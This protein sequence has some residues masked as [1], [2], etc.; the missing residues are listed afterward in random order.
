MDIWSE[1]NWFAVQTKP[2]RE[3]LAV[4]SVRRERVEVFFPQI[5]VNA[6][7]GD[8]TQK[9]SKPLFPGYLFA[10][11]CPS[12]ALDRVRYARGALRV[13]SA[14][15]IPLPVEEAI[16]REIRDRIE[17]DGLIRLKPPA[18][19]SGDPVLIHD[20]PLEGLMGRVEREWDDGRRVL[21]LIECLHQARVSVEKRSLLA[22][23][24]AA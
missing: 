14:S 16:I 11:F 7:D 9:V 23:C 12:A 24:E 4:A 8:A 20:G 21:I 22:G 5:V 17:P 2:Q 13:V 3:S 6:R 19:R 10:R 18:F 1:T 15:G